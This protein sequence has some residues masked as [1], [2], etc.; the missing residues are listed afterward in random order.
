MKNRLLTSF[1]LFLLCITAFSSF[2][3][4]ETEAIKVRNLPSVKLKDQE[5]F[6]GEYIINVKI[7]KP[8]ANGDNI[9]NIVLSKDK[10]DRDYLKTAFYYYTKG[11]IQKTEY[12]LR[13]YYVNISPQDDYAKMKLAMKLISMS[14]FNFAAEVL[15][16]IQEKDIWGKM[17]DEIYCIYMP[18][19]LMPE[20]AE[21]IQVTS[22]YYLNYKDKPKYVVELTEKAKDYDYLYYLRS[23]EQKNM[24]NSE[25]ALESINKAIEINPNN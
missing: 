22:G 10:E 18:K 11:D 5:Y 25:K 6:S 9:Q 21:S 19:N 24:H 13:Q 8:E 4:E 14:Y 23:K 12:F 17:I 15:Q 7:S 16:Q 20:E 3:A 2:A 1:C